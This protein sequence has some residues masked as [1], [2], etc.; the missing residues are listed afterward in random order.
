MLPVA[1]QIPIRF[2]NTF[3]QFSNK[4]QCEL[5]KFV[6][7]TQVELEASNKTH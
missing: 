5:R 3:L 2:K 7:G 6:F 4:W 1:G